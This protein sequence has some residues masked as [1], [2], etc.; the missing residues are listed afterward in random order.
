VAEDSRT[1]TIEFIRQNAAAGAYEFS[2]HADDERLDDALTVADVETAL[3]AA[4][5]LEDYPDDPRGHSCLVLGYTG[6][7]PVHVVCGLT[8]QQRLFLITVY[9]PRMPKWR[10]ERT[11]NR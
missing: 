2:L 8:R 5:L 9:R 1:L 3:R 10:D 6:G 11:R 7:D 4:E